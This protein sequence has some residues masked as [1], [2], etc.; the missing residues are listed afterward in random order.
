M[1]KLVFSVILTIQVFFSYSQTDSLS[2]LHN[3]F[4]PLSR[5]KIPYGILSDYGVQLVSFAPFNGVLTDSS[6]TT[7]DVWQMLYANFN[8]SE[9][10]SY[11]H[12]CILYSAFL[13]RIFSS[14]I[15]RFLL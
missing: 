9:F 6:Y 5:N 15:L 8:S 14:Y 12:S 13:L 1:K 10:R 7:F 3:V 11:T 2:A 4:A